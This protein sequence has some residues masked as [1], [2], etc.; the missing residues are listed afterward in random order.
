MLSFANKLKQSA[1]LYLFHFLNLAELSHFALL[2][3]RKAI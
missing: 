3:F 1:F 2:Y